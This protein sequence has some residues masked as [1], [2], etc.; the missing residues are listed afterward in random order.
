MA[1]DDLHLESMGL[2]DIFGVFQGWYRL[3]RVKYVF[4]TGIGY[5]ISHTLVE[6]M[7]D[8]IG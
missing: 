6:M 2:H 7:D 1:N 5:C 8:W 3:R 4:S